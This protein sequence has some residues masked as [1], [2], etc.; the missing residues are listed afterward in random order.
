MST[1]TRL[2]L[3]GAGGLLALSLGHYVFCYVSV[4]GETI[5]FTFLTP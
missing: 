4:V 2:A 5:P 1:L 3:I